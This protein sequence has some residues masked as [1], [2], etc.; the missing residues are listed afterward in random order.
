MSKILVYLKY[1]GTELTFVKHRLLYWLSL[2]LKNFFNNEIR[3][4][5]K[6]VSTKR[7][8]WG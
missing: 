1:K 4:Q 7:L 8:V 2:I 5:L 3:N 6:L